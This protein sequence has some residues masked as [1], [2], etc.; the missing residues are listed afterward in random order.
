MKNA[1][2]LSEKKKKLDTKVLKL[3]SSLRS[4][5]EKKIKKDELGFVVFFPEELEN[6]SL[7]ARVFAEARAIEASVFAVT[8]EI[9]DIFD[10]L[11][12]KYEKILRQERKSLSKK[13]TKAGASSGKGKERSQTSSLTPKETSLASQ[14]T[15]AP[16]K[17]PKKKSTSVKKTSSRTAT[18]TSVKKPASRKK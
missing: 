2:S 18:S 15:V 1:S 17:S 7:A 10:K 13:G 4:L 16:K 5:S 14:K 6:N 8:E 12:E 3:Q 9:M 11:D